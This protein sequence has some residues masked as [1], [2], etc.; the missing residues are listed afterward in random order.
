MTSRN[1]EVILQ[2]WRYILARDCT[3]GFLDTGK[4]V[5]YD[6]NNHKKGGA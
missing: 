1:W 5:W 6:D 2:L 4:W 3:C